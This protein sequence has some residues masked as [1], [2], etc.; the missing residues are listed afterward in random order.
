MA[1]KLVKQSGTWLGEIFDYVKMTVTICDKT[2]G[3]LQD[4]FT[5]SSKGASFRN[6]AAPFAMLLYVSRTFALR[7]GPFFAARRAH[8]AKSRLLMAKPELWDLR[9]P[10]IPEMSHRKK[11]FTQ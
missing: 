1:A 7:L 8:A 4:P 9:S 5:A 6:V 10:S 11:T 3:K 2:R